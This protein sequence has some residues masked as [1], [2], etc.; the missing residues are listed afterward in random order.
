MK[1]TFAV[2]VFVLS[3]AWFLKSAQVG[4]GLKDYGLKD[5]VGL[6][7][8]LPHVEDTEWK[9]VCRMPYNCQFQPWITLEAPAGQVIQGW[10][11][12]L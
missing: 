9:L 11:W 10:N 3:A 12:Q 7:R 6:S 4:P 5:Y 1:K 2:I 8:D